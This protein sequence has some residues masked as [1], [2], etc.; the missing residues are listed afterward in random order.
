[1]P[2]QTVLHLDKRWYPT[3]EPNWDNRMFREMLA[4]HIDGSKKVLDYGCGR[5]HVAHMNFK[6]IAGFIAGID[7]DRAVFEN[8]YLDEAKVLELP[9]GIIPY[10][11]A[12]FD[13]IFADN[14]MEHVADL[15]TV[16]R[17]IARV[18]KPGGRFLAKTPN[19]WHYMPLIA[20]CT[21]TWFHKAVNKRR[22]R[23]EHDT[24]PTCY[25]CNSRGAV[26]KHA[27]NAG[28]EV[29]EV[30]LIEGRPE[31]L[32]FNG[33][34]YL[35]GYIYER[36]VNASSIFQGFRGVLFFEVIKPK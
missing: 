24:F 10:P 17:E 15:T 22:G 7:P 6:G 18:L 3:F 29:G 36:V 34:T 32:R 13:V 16:F 28:L 20:S 11:D 27:R 31:Y 14:V 2:S 35:C 25:Q 30:R 1:M 21:P 9:A 23:E 26:A 12:T 19:R 8:P 33:L 4:P 5:G